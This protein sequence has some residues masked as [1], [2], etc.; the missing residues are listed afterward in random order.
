MGRKI[1]YLGGNVIIFKDKNIKNA[2]MIGAIS[3]IVY[4]AC[5]FSKNILSIVSP[6][7]VESTG[8]SIQYIGTLSTANMFFYAGGQLIN[9]II[10]DK[11]KAKY[12]VSGGL[13][14][15]GLCNVAIGMFDTALIM[16]IAY[17]ISGFFLSTLYAPLVKLIAE[18]TQ[19]AHA[20]K[21]CLGLSFASLF[22]VPTAG[23]IAFFFNWNYA[24]IVG[25]YILILIGLGFYVSI[26]FMEKQEI[27]KYSVVQKREKKETSLKILIENAIIKFTFI[28]VLTGIVRTSVA[29]WI[30]T[31]LTQYLGFTAG[32][33]ATIY[34]IMTCIQSISPYITN[35]TIYEHILK[36]DMDR[37]LLLMFGTCTISFMLMFLVKSSFINIIFLTLA[38]I[39]AN[40]AANIM[41]NVYCPSLNHTGMV[42]T[43][44][45]YLDFMSYLAAGIANLLFANAIENIGWGNLILIWTVLMA[46]GVFVSIPWR[47]KQIR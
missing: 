44:T 18:N 30:P 39:T 20:E 43:A 11:I 6:Q 26:R 4:L 2:F 29:F 22:G 25:G 37:M 41:W 24:F 40:G 45:G 35:V 28:S 14:L 34:T 33:S 36:R 46:A 23:I 19:P 21:C 31:Y 1:C 27:V 9:G 13:I 5:Y 42:S 3:T 16:L 32:I 15:A 7:M 8:I 12:L 17:S 47:K 10:G 38:I